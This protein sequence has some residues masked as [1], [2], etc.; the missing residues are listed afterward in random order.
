M[1]DLDAAAGAAAVLGDLGPARFVVGLVG[2]GIGRVDLVE[3]ALKPGLVAIVEARLVPVEIV[4]R[5]VVEDLALAGR[6]KDDEFVGL[7]SP[8]IGPDAAF[9]GTAWMPSRWKVR[10]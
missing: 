3:Q 8:P 6:G 2:R 10:R 9:I 1:A 7:R 5:G 4:V